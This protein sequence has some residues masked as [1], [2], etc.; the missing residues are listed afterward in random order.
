MNRQLR[1]N[2]IATALLFATV[3]L[4]A[5]SHQK[6]DAARDRLKKSFAPA[7]GEAKY[8]VSKAITSL[9]THDFATALPLLESAFKN[10]EITL[11]QK[12]ALIKDYLDTMIG[13]Q[14]ESRNR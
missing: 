5:C 9:E 11:D 13:S 3:T 12:L 7:T 14:P 1:N 2:W 8:Q 6:V 4:T 10:T